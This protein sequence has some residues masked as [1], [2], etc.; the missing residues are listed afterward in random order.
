MIVQCSL[1]YYKSLSSNR[2]QLILRFVF[3]ERC[4]CRGSCCLCFKEKWSNRTMVKLIRI[5]RTIADLTGE[6]SISE[7][8]IHATDGHFH[9]GNWFRGG[10]R[11][12]EE[13]EMAST[14]VFSRHCPWE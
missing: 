13:R 3:S 4:H 8:S 2:S 6:Q 1:L 5:A 10:C 7:A 14:K 9:S 11:W 12:L